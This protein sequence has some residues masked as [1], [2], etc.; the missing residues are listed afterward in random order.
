M[1]TSN[2]SDGEPETCAIIKSIEQYE[3]CLHV[4]RRRWC[5]KEEFCLPS[6]RCAHFWWK[7]TGCVCLPGNINLSSLL[8]T[9]SCLMQPCFGSFA[10]CRKNIQAHYLF[11]CFISSSS[12]PPCCWRS[13]CNFESSCCPATSVLL[14]QHES[15]SCFFSTKLIEPA[16]FSGAIFCVSSCFSQR[17][18]FLAEI[19]PRPPTCGRTFWSTTPPT[20]W[21]SSSLMTHTSTWERR[22]PWGTLWPA[23]CPTGN[24]KSPCTGTQTHTQTHLNTHR[25]P[26]LLSQHICISIDQALI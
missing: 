18:V 14:F 11:L 10:L 26:C 15:R 6:R 2:V 13:H 21:L 22:W 20:C 24:L 23:C 1:N 19:S 7:I 4:V 16:R 3:Q 5:G 17:L 12:L 9:S 25:K 8:C